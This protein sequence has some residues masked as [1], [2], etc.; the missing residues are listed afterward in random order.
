MTLAVARK[1][2]ESAATCGWRL[3]SVRPGWITV[4]LVLALAAPPVFGQRLFVGLSG[5]APV[6]RSSDLA[7]FPNVAWTNHF[8]FDVVGAAARSDG[9]LYICNGEF[10]T[11]LYSA[12]LSSPP[13]F[14]SNVSV[15]I[16]ALAW[17]DGTLWGYSNFAPTKGIYRIDPQTGAATLVLDVYTDHGFRFFALDYNAADGL[18]YGYTEYGVSGLYSIDLDKEQM[19]RIV[20]P[21]PA[22]NGQGRGMAVGDNTVYLTATRGDDGIPL[23]AYD[24]SQGPN[25]EWTAFTQPYPEYHS[26]GGAAW[27]PQPIC[28]S[29]DRIRAK[30]SDSGK[31]VAKLKT[32]LGQG[33]SLTLDL[34]GQ[35]P[36]Q[37]VTNRNGKAKAKWKRVEPG[38]HTACVRTC[39]GICD[40]A[41][42]E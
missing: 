26:T 15:D 34:D 36:V 20:G 12:T 24:L 8:A 6:T 11:K 14:L 25:G 7:G 40:D 5:S 32:S 28:E 30:C 1:P 4:P 18:L 22:Q 38:R 41:T 27:I 29:I 35:R 17:G 9:V 21:P 2:R 19:T 13:V 42:C 31:F 16:H 37:V 33:T 10:N 3:R 23:F 39:Q